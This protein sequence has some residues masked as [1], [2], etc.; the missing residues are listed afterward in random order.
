MKKVLLSMLILSM[1]GAFA[2]T[3]E[4]QTEAMNACIKKG[5]TQAQCQ[6][7]GKQASKAEQKMKTTGNT[8]TGTAN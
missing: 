1:S 4:E 8:A 6:N 7:A 2:V 5:G 3:S